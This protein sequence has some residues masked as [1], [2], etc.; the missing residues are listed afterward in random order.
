MTKSDFIDWKHHPITEVVFN[1]LKDRIRE[2]E[3]MLGDS[4]GQNQLQDVTFVGAIKAYKDVLNI[5]FDGES[6]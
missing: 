6:V 1:Q 4:A 5:E 2:L 3:E